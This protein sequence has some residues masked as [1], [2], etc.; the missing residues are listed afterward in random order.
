MSTKQLSGVGREV[1]EG[2]PSGYLLKIVSIAMSVLLA[3]AVLNP[4]VSAISIRNKGGDVAYTEGRF[5]AGV[6]DRDRDGSTAYNRAG[7]VG[8]GGR[9]IYDQDG[10]GGRCNEKKTLKIKNIRLCRT[11]GP[12]PNSCSNPASF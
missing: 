1:R 10:A 12:F 6:C 5:R 11:N 2:R 7:F 9:S 3:S 4:P 8:G